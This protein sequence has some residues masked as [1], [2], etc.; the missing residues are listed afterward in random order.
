M[1][2]PHIQAAQIPKEKISGCL[3][4][5]EH[6]SGRSKAVFFADLGFQRNQP[7]AL[8]DALL[9]H[10][11]SNAVSSV[12]TTSF[13]AKFLVDGMIRGPTGKSRRVRSIWFLELGESWPRFVTAYPLRGVQK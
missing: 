13:G 11:A 6:P 1:Y 9:Q 7:Q 8:I 10:A 5:N 3:L 2:L 4:A 12:K